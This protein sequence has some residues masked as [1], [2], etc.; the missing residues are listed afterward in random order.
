[1]WLWLW[2]RPATADLIRPLVWELLYATGEALKRKKPTTL[3]GFYPLNKFD[4]VELPWWLSG[5]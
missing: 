2:R 5:E 3:F 1:M 4:I